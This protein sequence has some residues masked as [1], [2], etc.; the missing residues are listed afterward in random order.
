MFQLLKGKQRSMIQLPCKREFRVTINM[1]I[2]YQTSVE[3]SSAYFFPA[4]NSQSVM[5]SVS[6]WQLHLP[7]SW[8]YKF[9]HIHN[10][11]IENKI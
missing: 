7:T 3:D 10:M 11:M 8:K 2:M 6:S 1:K 9:A 5:V 4:V